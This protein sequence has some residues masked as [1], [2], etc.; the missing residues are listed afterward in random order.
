V[1][2]DIKPQNILMIEEGIYCITDFGISKILERDSNDT[3]FSTRFLNTKGPYGGTKI[4]MAPELRHLHESYENNLIT[5]EDCNKIIFN[6]EK[7]D[8]FSLGITCLCLLFNLDR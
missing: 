3:H 1:Q 2:R 6:T 8:I 7:C 4:Y 5:L